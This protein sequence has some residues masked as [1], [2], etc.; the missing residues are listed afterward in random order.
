ME[1]FTNPWLVGIG[2]TIIAGL[3]LY[4]VFGIGKTNPKHEK[5]KTT[6]VIQ[7]NIESSPSEPSTSRPTPEEIR[8]SLKILP[9]F[10]VE[11]AAKNY[12]G[13]AVKWTVVLISC[14][15][16]PFGGR[17][18]VLAHPPS[19]HSPYIDLYTDIEKYPRLKILSEGQTFTV[20]GIIA[21]V[22]ITE[23]SLVNCR[24]YFG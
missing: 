10:Q 1:I 24:L 9:P 20:E 12:K 6:M 2:T 22:G 18:Y 14:S 4:F 21:S 7:P 15:T 8:E 17:Q 16:S 23:I 13:I 19:G 11:Q 3:V 5:T